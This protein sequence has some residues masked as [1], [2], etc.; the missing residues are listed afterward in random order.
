MKKNRFHCCATC[1]HFAV[2]KSTNIGYICT[3]LQYETKPDYVFNC[4]DPRSAVQ[5]LIK[6]ED[7][8][9]G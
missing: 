8:E 4:W 9:R 6:K 2:V 7:K 5:K 3:R 1:V